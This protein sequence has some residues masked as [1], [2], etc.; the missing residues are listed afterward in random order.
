[1]ANPPLIF[2]LQE[3]TSPRPFWSVMIPTYDPRA[4]YLEETL[5]SVLKQDQGPDEMQIEVIDDC[6]KESTA[7]EVTHRAGAGRVAFHRESENAG[8]ATAWT[9]LIDGA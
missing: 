2:P 6:S 7:L 4:D 9:R 5:L 3:G 1:M 8:L